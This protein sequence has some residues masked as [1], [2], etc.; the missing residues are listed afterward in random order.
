MTWGEAVEL[1][2]TSG[3][4]KKFAEVYDENK[5]YLEIYKEVMADD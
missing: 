3:K 1:W 5:K 2:A 4:A